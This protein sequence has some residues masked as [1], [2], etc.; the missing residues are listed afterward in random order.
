MARRANGEGSVVQRSDGRWQALL[1]GADG[2][3]LYR[4]GKTRAEVAKTLRE[5][6]QSREAGVAPPPERYT[7]EAYL[8][9]W[10]RGK[11]SAIKFRTWVR[12]QQY[13]ENQAI[14]RI[15]RR[16][17]AETMHQRGRQ[18]PGR[19]FFLG[20]RRLGRATDD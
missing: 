4:Y 1:V 7:V 13:V 9:Q 19:V 6:V 5:L 16:P 15:G 17:L 11:R 18:D 8:R 12:Y 2:R 10:L 14:P 3:R 20:Q